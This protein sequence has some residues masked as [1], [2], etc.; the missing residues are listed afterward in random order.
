MGVVDAAIDDG[1]FDSRAGVRHAAREGAPRRG[2]VHQVDGYVEIPLD[3]RQPDHVPDT[4]ERP[5]L[6]NALARRAHEHG[7]HQGLGGAADLDLA[8][9]QFAA[10]PLLRRFD[11]R[12]RRHL[13]CQGRVLQDQGVF[14]QAGATEGLK[15][16]ERGE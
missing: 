14:F 6:R 12:A 2:Q 1:D 13:P 15:G 3:A 16:E 10:E 9:R 11:T 4:V 5:Q 7:V 8:P